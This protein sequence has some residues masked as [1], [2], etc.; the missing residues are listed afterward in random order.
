VDESYAKALDLL[1]ANRERLDALAH[2]LLR[3]ESLNEEQMRA[4]TGLPQRP[5]A[6]SAVGAS[7]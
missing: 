7:R 4:V 1:K 2:A 6:E 5:A 3:E